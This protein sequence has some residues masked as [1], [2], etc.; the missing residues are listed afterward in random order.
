MTT[1]S[2]SALDL[3]LRYIS[4]RTQWGCH[5]ISNSVGTVGDRGSYFMNVS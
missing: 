4:V 3:N 1:H 5:K 2:S